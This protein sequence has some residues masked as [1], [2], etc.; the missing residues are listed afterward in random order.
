MRI[1]Y[2]IAF[3]LSVLL[4]AIFLYLTRQQ[5]GSPSKTL[6]EGDEN[7][8][9][10]WNHGGRLGDSDQQFES[11]RLILSS[12][13]DERLSSMENLTRGLIFDQDEPQSFDPYL[14]SLLYN[15]I[16]DFLILF[17]RV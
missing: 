6:V 5:Q 15:N 17:Y 8:R 9:K 2:T 7:I 4:V 13:V 1:V 16:P 12:A 11:I 3:V 10:L 14:R